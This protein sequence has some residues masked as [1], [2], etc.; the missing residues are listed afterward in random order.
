VTTSGD[1]RAC[2]AELHYLF[3]D[4]FGRPGKGNDKG[5]VEGFVGYARRNFMV[6]IPLFASFEALNAHLLDCCRKRMGIACA[7]TTRQSAN[8]I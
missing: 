4:R 3:E 6:P 2:S 8:G 5:K 1:A 7:V